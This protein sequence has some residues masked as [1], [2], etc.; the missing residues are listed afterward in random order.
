MPHLPPL[1]SLT[2]HPPPLL[3]TAPPAPPHPTSR[4]V[5]FVIPL[6]RANASAGRQLVYPRPL[7]TWQ[8]ELGWLACLLF[9]WLGSAN[10]ASALCSA[11]RITP[12]SQ[13]KLKQDRLSLTI[14]LRA[15]SVTHSPHAH[16]DMDIGP[17]LSSGGFICDSLM[18]SA[19]ANTKWCKVGLYWIYTGQ[20]LYVVLFFTML[21]H[22]PTHTL[23]DTAPVFNNTL[24]THSCQEQFGVQCLTQ[25]HFHMQTGGAGVQTTNLLVMGQL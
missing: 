20:H 10:E 9:C 1:I 22:P 24:F 11:S 4:D 21:F 12:A 2:S 17:V 6:L 3:S 14:S 7:T 18:H 19:S 25:G 13:D 5:V 23:I 16:V 15:P 8:E